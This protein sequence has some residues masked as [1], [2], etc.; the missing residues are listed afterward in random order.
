MRVRDFRVT[1]VSSH[2]SVHLAAPLVVTFECGLERCVAG[3]EGSV[4][5]EPGRVCH[6]FIDAWALFG[7]YLKHV[8]DEISNVVRSLRVETF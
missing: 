2:H 1:T 6:D 8:A 5:S 7:N 4:G 3:D